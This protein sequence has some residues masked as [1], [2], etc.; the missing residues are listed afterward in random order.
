MDAGE[1]SRTWTDLE[2]GLAAENLLLETVA[3][4]LGAVVVGGMDPAAAKEAVR[5]PGKEQVIVLVPAGHPA[6]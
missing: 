2:A 4:G 5:S 6:R 1:R 3:R